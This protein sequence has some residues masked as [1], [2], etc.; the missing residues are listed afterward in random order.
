MLGLRSRAAHDQELYLFPDSY[1]GKRDFDGG[2]C[3][4]RVL[5]GVS[6]SHRH[7]VWLG[8]AMYDITGGYGLVWWIG[9]GVGAF[10]A[11]VHLPIRENRFPIAAT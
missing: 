8:G 9:V 1:C 7:R 6:D 2:F 10:S 5:W 4:P 11:L 3:H